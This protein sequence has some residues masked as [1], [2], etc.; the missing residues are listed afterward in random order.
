MDSPIE[1]FTQD[2][3]P[4]QPSRNSRKRPHVEDDDNNQVVNLVSPAVSAAHQQTLVASRPDSTLPWATDVVDLGAE[5][6]PSPDVVDAMHSVYK[7]YLKGFAK[8]FRSFHLALEHRDRFQREL[9]DGEAIPDE[10]LRT[11]KGPTITFPECVRE[12]CLNDIA[13]LKKG[14]ES[15]L[16]HTRKATAQYVL[17][18][19]NAAVTRLREKCEVQG[20]VDSFGEEL[21]SLSIELL[22]LAGIEANPERWYPYIARVSRC[23]GRVLDDQKIKVVVTLRNER[24]AKSKKKAAVQ[25]AQMDVEMKDATKTVEELVSERVEI[26]MKKYK[27]A[28][29]QKAK[30]TKSNGSPPAKKQKPDPKPSTSNTNAAASSSKSA[31]TKVASKADKKTEKGK[32]SKGKERGA[33]DSKGKGTTKKKG[34]AK[35]TSGNASDS[36]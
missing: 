30:T 27:Q 35:A 10:I 13:G 22:T 25:T 26:E 11:L 29:A 2:G 24:D 9:G 3:G 34:K 36:D 32:Q 8:T 20:M 4:A 21:K 31:K 17:K 28:E 33:V 1:S 6:T 14:H 15:Q 5:L 16:A 18:A 12:A 7:Q 19:L 23:L